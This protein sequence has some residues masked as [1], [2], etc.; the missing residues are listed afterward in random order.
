MLNG[1]F[2]PEVFRFSDRITSFPVVHGSGDYAQE[3]R[4]VLLGRHFDCLAVPLPPSFAREVE[5]SVEQL[6]QVHLVAQVA[7]EGEGA[8]YVPVE[9]CQPVIAAIRVAM[10]EHVDRAYIDLEVP[11]YEPHSDFAPDPYALKDIAPERFAAALLPFLTPPGRG[12]QRDERVRRMA[13][14]LHRL[15]LDHKAILFVPAIQDWPWIRDA[16]RERAPYPKGRGAW[17]PPRAYKVHPSTLYFVLGELPYV[18]Y[19]YE[20][21]RRQMRSDAHLSVDGV[22]ELLVEARRRWESTRRPEARWVTPQLLRTCLN[23]IRNLTLLDGRLTP[24]LYTLAVAAK[25]VVNDDFAIAL[26]ETAK[27]YPPQT[28][29]PLLYAAQV[30][31]D[32]AVLGDRA[33]L[34][35]V[36]RLPGPPRVWRNLSLRPQPDP[37]HRREWLQRW[38]PYTQCSWPPEDERIESFNSHV[39]DQARAML[40][41][42]LVRTEKFTSSLKDGLDLR[43]T[44]RNWH[45]GDL[46]VKEAPPGRGTVEVVVFLFEDPLDEAQYAWRAT[47]F[48][49]HHEESTMCFAATPF[50]HNVIGPGLALSKYG[51]LFLLYPPRPILD[52]WEDGRLEFARTAADRLVAGALLHSRER[53]VVLVAPRPPRAR[54]RLLAR[55]MRR[56][57]LYIPLQRFSGQTIE[58]LRHFHVLNGHEVR[59]WAAQ[60]VREF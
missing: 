50:Y 28:K 60:F 59:S 55:R 52:V 41:E 10:Q 4:E 21:R 53:H 33:P 42:D 26:V 19:L 17:E 46:Y 25:Q 2:D 11:A 13:F 6:P 27:T 8:S 9:P 45:T 44:L 30:G 48:A 47:W 22:R 37:Q 23:Y 34:P 58:R 18:T 15:E 51:G 14:E 38:N 20:K 5:R 43:E 54:W 40:A 1:R 3:V 7:A 39:R 12:S 31:T 24:D 49:E 36:S 16:Y 29:P 56:K 35:V 57:L 32:F